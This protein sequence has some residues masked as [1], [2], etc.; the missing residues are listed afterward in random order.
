MPEQRT[1]YLRFVVLSFVSLVVVTTLGIASYYGRVLYIHFQQLGQLR[2]EFDAINDRGEPLGGEKLEEFYS[3]LPDGVDNTARITQALQIFAGQETG[4]DAELIKELASL[5]NLPPRPPQKWER[6]EEAEALVQKYETALQALS[7]ALEAGGDAR[8]PLD[9][10]RGLPAAMRFPHLQDQL[11]AQRLLVIQ[12]LCLYQRGQLEQAAE[13]VCTLIR[14]ADT[15]RL[16]PFSI[17]LLV[18]Q[19]TRSAALRTFAF[20][21]GDQNFPAAGIQ[22]IQAAV[23]AASFEDAY[24][25]TSVGERAIFF[26][27]IQLSLPELDEN[28]PRGGYAG[29]RAVAKRFPAYTSAALRHFTLHVEA[30]KVPW[31]DSLTAAQAARDE[32]KAE[33]DASSNRPPQQ[34]NVVAHLLYVPLHLNWELALRAEAERRAWLTVCAIKLYRKER[35]QLPENLAALVPLYLEQVPADPLDQQPLRYRVQPSQYIVYSIGLNLQD[36]AGQVSR[37]SQ[38][39]SLDTGV[40]ITRD[41]D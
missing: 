4:P 7:V 16:E 1:S 28:K 26:E 23:A 38:G 40:A 31:P 5:E 8:F 10:A 39:T 34:R 13:K 35:G 25:R 27:A 11:N 21:A 33:L 32:V 15:V 20:L 22:Q 37:D 24:Y 6:L 17:S 41:M 9:Y 29:G 12:T 14:L 19:S 36:D 3:P 18:R 30:S 2:A